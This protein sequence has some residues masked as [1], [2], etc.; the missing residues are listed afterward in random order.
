LTT[1]WPRGARALTRALVGALMASTAGC[2]PDVREEPWMPPPVEPPPVTGPRDAPPPVEGALSGD[3]VIEIAKPR[4][5][6]LTVHQTWHGA[7]MPLRFK[8]HGSDAYRIDEVKLHVD[9][10]RRE[11]R[12]NGRVWSAR[13]PLK[14][15]GTL[16]YRVRVGGDDPAGYQGFVDEQMAVFDGSVLLLPVS[17]QPIGQVRMRFDLPEGW[18][19]ATALQPMEDGWYR[20]PEGLPPDELLD[21]LQCDCYGAGAFR[22]TEVTIDGQ[23]V[24]SFTLNDLKPGFSTY[25]HD[26]T[27]DLARW[28]DE[29]LGL[30]AP[31]PRAFVRTTARGRPVYGGTSRAT[32][33]FEGRAPDPA[34]RNAALLARRMAG[35]LLDHL[36]RPAGDDERWWS[37]ALPRFVS[38]PAVESTGA[39][40]PGLL[41]PELWTAHQRSTLN[42]PLWAKMPLRRFAVVDAPTRDYLRQS[43]GP[44]VLHALAALVRQRTDTTLEG[45]LSE[46]VEQ[47]PRLVRLQELL[48]GRTNASFADFF[49]AYVD[50]ETPL[51]PLVPGLITDWARDRARRPM[52]GATAGYPVPADYVAWLAASGEFDRFGAL[53]DHIGREGPTR[54]ALAERGVRLVEGE[55]LATLGGIDPRTRQ[56]L[57]A[58]EAGWPVHLTGADP[59]PVVAPQLSL[60]EGV[61]AADH[62]RTLRAAESVYEAGLVGSGIDRIAV[63]AGPKDGADKRPD[64]LV[65]AP[66]EAFTI[67]VHYRYP[68]RALSLEVWKDGQRTFAQPITMEPGWPANRVEVGPADRPATE[69]VFVVRVVGADGQPVLERS[70]WQHA[71]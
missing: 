12:R 47:G 45:V 56:D 9:G 18:S 1:L 3:V 34:I 17:R 32:V 24:R 16:S 53:L 55:V 67:Y 69:G 60:A 28:Y 10:K 37:A 22:K 31:F 36:L 40:E 26:S 39:L 64:V 52:V 29:Q 44:L 50:G 19:P 11:L 63:R 2:M 27:A 21:R 8:R 48:E 68:P 62:L 13:P 54:D 65:I 30:S 14:A 33:C 66:D 5:Q 42:R 59:L 25:L 38:L 57:V 20:F 35:P 46:A 4:S 15:A 7:Q 23:P 71:G 41:G 70:F 43:R 61:A 58:A 6:W 49:A 51:V